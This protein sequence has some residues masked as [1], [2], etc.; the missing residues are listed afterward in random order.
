MRL[1]RVAGRARVL[2]ADGGAIEDEE[3]VGIDVKIQRGWPCIAEPV[4]DSQRPVRRDGDALRIVVMPLQGLPESGVRGS[5]MHR[6]PSRVQ[7]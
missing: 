1:L 5:G 4:A 3:I 7:D 2:I 6:R